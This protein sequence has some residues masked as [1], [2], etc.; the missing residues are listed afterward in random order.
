MLSKFASII[1]LIAVC[2]GEI[3]GLMFLGNYAL[4]HDKYAKEFCRFRD[5]PDNTCKG[6][7]HLSKQLKVEKQQ[8]SASKNVPVTGF[9]GFTLPLFLQS[10]GRLVFRNYYRSVRVT[11]DQFYLINRYINRI[12]HPPELSA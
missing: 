12:D 6:K 11:S 4:Q 10:S 8:N 2:Q 1:L 9:Q 7:C 3:T 5:K